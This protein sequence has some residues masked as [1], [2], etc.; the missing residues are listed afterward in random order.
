MLDE[1]RYDGWALGRARPKGG[2]DE[3]S[4][5]GAKHSPCAP[6]NA[7]SVLQKRTFDVQ[8]MAPPFWRGEGQTWYDPIAWRT[9]FEHTFDALRGYGLASATE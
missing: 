8:K 9:L 5:R 1:P 7:S 6:P 4:E 2:C 3:A